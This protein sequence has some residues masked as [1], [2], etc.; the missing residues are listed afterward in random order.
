MVGVKFMYDLVDV[1]IGGV[2][3]EV[4]WKMILRLVWKFKEEG[5]EMFFI[6]E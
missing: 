6:I 4:G 3:V 2:V 5:L 1:K